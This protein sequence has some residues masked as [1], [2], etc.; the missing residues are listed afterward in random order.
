M[1]SWGRRRGRKCAHARFLKGGTFRKRKVFQAQRKKSWCKGVEVSASAPCPSTDGALVRA[2]SR[3][4]LTQVSIYHCDLTEE[5]VAPTWASGMSLSLGAGG[6]VLQRK[7]QALSSRRGL[8]GKGADFERGEAPLAGG[9]G[10]VGG[11][12]ASAAQGAAGRPRRGTEVRRGPAAGDCAGNYRAPSAP[13]G[14]G[15]CVSR[16]WPAS[17]ASRVGPARPRRPRPEAA[18]EAPPRRRQEAGPGQAALQAACF[19]PRGSGWAR[20]TFSGTRSPLEP[21]V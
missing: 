5:K 1:I 7:P 10:Q 9:G 18:P 12:S 2:V 8:G 15:R 6:R 17:R 4:R 14:R 13:S 16:A 20:A 11:E 21:A 19:G 3:R